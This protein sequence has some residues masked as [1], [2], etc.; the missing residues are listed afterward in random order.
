MDVPTTAAHRLVELD[1]AECWGLLAGAEVGRLVWNGPDGPTA[2]TVNHRLDGHDVLLRST[3]YGS[4]GREVD[5]SPVAFQVDHVDVQQHAGWSVL[6]RGR[7]A[8][9]YDAAAVAVDAWPEGRRT[10]LV[11]ISPTSVSGR[12]LLA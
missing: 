9:D 10:L 12:R 5:D 4:I 8:F 7:A 3:P 1:E 6:L 11:R 2:L